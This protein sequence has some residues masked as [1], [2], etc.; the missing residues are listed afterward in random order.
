MVPCGGSGS[1]AG[2]N[3]PKQY[4]A[5]AGQPVLAHTLQALARVPAVAG[6]VLVIAYEDPWFD[7]A[8]PGLPEGGF[9][10]LPTV[11]QRRGGGSDW[12]QVRRAAG[13]SRAQTVLNGLRVWQDELRVPAHDWVLVH[14]A[15][16]CL[17][18]PADVG[19]LIDACLRDPVGGLLAIPLP[20]TLKQ[21]SQGRVGATVARD[22]KW[23]AQTPQ[24]FRLGDLRQALESAARQGFDGITDE[25]S[26]MERAGYCPRLVH[27]SPEN[28]KL[29]YPPD[30]ALAEAIL[31]ER[32]EPTA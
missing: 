8:H 24:M 17:L 19:R 12:L 26:A 31:K 14:D 3:Q 32:K 29:T 30:F 6:L 2:G 27:G 16:R 13:A 28:I 20:D 5:L 9:A 10:Q 22:D 21:E 1:R 11:Q 23:L 25:S 4:R 15:A 18:Q 7:Q